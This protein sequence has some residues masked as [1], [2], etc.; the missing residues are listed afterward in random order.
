MDGAE[1]GLQSALFLLNM[2]PAPLEII[3][4]H[5]QQ[6]AEKYLKGYIALNDYLTILELR[7]ERFLN[8]EKYLY[9]ILSIVT[10]STLSSNLLPSPENR[11]K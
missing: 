6:S 11:L 9:K 5:C 1:T 3:C 8:S 7:F 10:I 2:H 4:Y